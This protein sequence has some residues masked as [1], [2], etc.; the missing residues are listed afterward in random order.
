M[1]YV[2]RYVAA[3]VLDG[4]LYVV[5]G[6]DGFVVFD[7]VEVY[8]SRLDQWKFAVNMVN[9]RRYVVVGVLDIKDVIGDGFGLGIYIRI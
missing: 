6:Y 3:V 8:D 5:G 7:F 1:V 4:F 2:R 9:F